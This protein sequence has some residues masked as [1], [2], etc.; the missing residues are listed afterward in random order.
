M[1]EWQIYAGHTKEVFYSMAGQEKI[2]GHEGDGRRGWSEGE[3]VSKKGKTTPG[4]PL[5]GRGTWVNGQR[6]CLL[7]IGRSFG[8]CCVRKREGM[9]VKTEEAGGR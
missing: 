7:F 8:F 1:Y 4:D 3:H 9:G 5:G 6:S 2:A